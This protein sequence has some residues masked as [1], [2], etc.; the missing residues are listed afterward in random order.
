MQGFGVAGNGMLDEGELARLLQAMA[1]GDRAAAG[2]L[3]RLIGG[4]VFGI[5]Q[6]I[7]RDGGLAE[8]AVHQAFL[9]I[10]KNAHRFDPRKGKASTW[11]TIIARH[12]ALDL[13]PREMKPLPE[14]LTAPRLDETYVHPRLR[15]A[16][17]DL[18]EA[19]RNAVLLMY[20]YGLTHSELAQAMGAP[21]GTVKSW[22]RRGTAALKEALTG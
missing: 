7:L 16:L 8:D 1:G 3:Y 4:R 6:R 21:L 2:E 13:R 5:A 15:E 17:A 18:P 19:H 20:V 14:D 11:L 12:T 10:W 22:V 9:K